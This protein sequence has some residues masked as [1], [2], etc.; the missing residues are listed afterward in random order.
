MGSVS[1]QIAEAIA[2]QEPKI[3]MLEPHSVKDQRSVKERWFLRLSFRGTGFCGWQ[4]QPK[5]MSVQ[6]RLEEA[7]TT[8]LRRQ[9]D[10]TGAGRTDAGVH[11][12][13][14]WAH[15]DSRPGEFDPVSLLRSLN[16]LTGSDIAVEQLRQVRPESH[17][18]FDAISR[19]YRYI[20]VFE[21]NPFLKGL[22]W[23]AFHQLDMEAMNAAATKLTEIRDF[24]SFA[25]LH[26]D[27]KTNICRVSA[28][29]W[30]LLENDTEI[31]WP[32]DGLIF[33]ITA[34]RFLRNMVRAVVGT[35]V[36]VGRHKLTEN[37]FVEIIEKKDRCAAGQSMPAEGLY[38]WDVRYPD[39]IWIGPAFSC[40]SH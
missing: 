30:D 9:T 2:P 1:I 3:E 23:R 22:A 11:A 7:L 19:T 12:R 26:S 15:F 33:T 18:R 13:R 10:V 34:D 5:D 25:K 14:M 16:S 29:R 8:I 40:N 36:E 6:Q 21:K 27:A 24:T 35:L 20:A 31:R 28:A 4:R 17:A 32:S 39:D 37:E 38:L